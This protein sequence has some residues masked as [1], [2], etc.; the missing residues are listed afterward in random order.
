L[1]QLRFPDGTTLRDMLLEK[2]MKKDIDKHLNDDGEA[3]AED[4]NA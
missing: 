1:E 4:R 2:Q 3:N